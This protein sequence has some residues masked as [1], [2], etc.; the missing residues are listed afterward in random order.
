MKLN[1]WQ[2]TMAAGV[3]SAALLTA[4]A[5]PLPIDHQSGHAYAASKSSEVEA[6]IQLGG[7]YRGTPYEFGSNRST[8]STF[9][10]SD[11]VKHIFNKAA[12]VKL[13]GSSATQ[14]AYVKK[15]SDVKTSWSSLERGDL[16]FF[17]SYK[18]PNISG[19]SGVDKSKQQVTHVALYLGNGK[20]LHTYSPQSGGVRIDSVKGKHWEYRMLFG[21]SAL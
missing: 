21:G 7:Q 2:K 14:A 12:G 3:V 20:V 13:P 9:D 19:Y 16:V 1:V 10:C 18:G 11:F 4:G 15:H 8:T 17:M 6:V 5:A